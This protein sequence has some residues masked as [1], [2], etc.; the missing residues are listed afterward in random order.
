[1]SAR[2]W[3]R[4]GVG[5]VVVLLVTVF[6]VVFGVAWYFS[7]VALAVVRDPEPR[8]TVRA[9]D[10][11]T[12]IALPPGDPTP[13]GRHAVRHPDGWGVLGDRVR[14]GGEEGPVVRDWGDVRGT[15]SADPVTAVVD[16]DAIV[17]DPSS[18]GLEFTDVMVTSEVGD[19]PTWLVPADGTDTWVVFAHGRGGT[20]EEALRYLPL[21]HDLGHPVLV[22]SYRNDPGAPPDPDDRYGLGET[23]WRDVDAA[24]GYAL[25][26]GAE[27][28][29]LAGWSMGGAIV[30]QILDRSEHAGSVSGL[31]LDAPV[32]DWVDVLVHQGDQAGLPEWWSRFAVALVEV[33]GGLDFDDYDWVARA[34]DLPDEVPVYLVHSDGDTFVPNRRSLALAQARPDVVTLVRDSTA[35][36]TREWNVDP[37]AYE[38][39]M[40]EWFEQEIDPHDRR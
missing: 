9:V 17:G 3:R 22:P 18:V 2:T 26:N 11:G 35:E 15:L 20:R 28:V 30:L 34:G 1:M 6:G 32:V 23:E 16:Q 29:V 25:N 4:I 33:R 40:R 39:D 36:H 31:V 27:S 21:W 7:G 38:A 24:V 14:G 12:A 13:D 5:T 19:L 37:E 10:G 8:V